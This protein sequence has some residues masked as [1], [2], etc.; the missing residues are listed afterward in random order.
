LRRPGNAPAASR[1]IKTDFMVSPGED[2]SSLKRES[3]ERLPEALDAIDPRD[4]EVVEIG[5]GPGSLSGRQ[6]RSKVSI[7]R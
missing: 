2:D 3:L 6:I 5:R 7:A 4:V 1:Q